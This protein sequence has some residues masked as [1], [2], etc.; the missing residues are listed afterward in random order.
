MSQYSNVKHHIAVNG[1]FKVKRTIEVADRFRRMFHGK[2]I[3]KAGIH[4]YRFPNTN[5]SARKL[6]N[7]FQKVYHKLVTVWWQSAEYREYWKNKPLQS[8]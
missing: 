2:K 8:S 6:S 1:R 7:D 5:Y 4:N 3:V